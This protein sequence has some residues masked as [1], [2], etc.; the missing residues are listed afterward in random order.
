MKRC[1]HLDSPERH[2]YALNNPKCVLKRINKIF[3]FRKNERPGRRC[4]VMKGKTEK[5]NCLVYV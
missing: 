5:S 2:L 3:D 1:H 4:I